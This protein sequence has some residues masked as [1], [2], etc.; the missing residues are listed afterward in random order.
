MRNP[1]EAAGRLQSL[2][3]LG[4]RIAIDDFGTGYSSLAYLREFPVDAL[5]ID[6]SF[7]SGL[8]NAEDASAFVN[9]LVQLGRTLQIET[10]GE[11]IEDEDQLQRLIDADCDFGQGFLLAR[12][13][14]AEQI[15]ALLAQE[16]A[17]ISTL[18][19]HRGPSDAHE[20]PPRTTECPPTSNG[21][22]RHLPIFAAWPEPHLGSGCRR[23]TA[24]RRLPAR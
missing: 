4:V 20:E 19:A 7:I 13:L 1:K 11:G 8:D 23:R 5:K 12:P 15:E 10:L 22:G 3:R 18:A 9:T 2:K 21:H 24:V 14:P 6:R 17:D 16:L